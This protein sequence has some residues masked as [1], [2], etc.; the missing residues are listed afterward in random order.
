MKWTAEKDAEMRRLVTENPK[1][2]WV[3]I[4]ELMDA[5][6]DGCRK[7]GYKIGLY[8]DR[9]DCREKRLKRLEW[10]PEMDALLLS[11]VEQGASRRKTAAAIGCSRE[12]V[13]KRIQRIELGPPV[14]GGREPTE[15]E[16]AERAQKANV[17]FLNAIAEHHPERLAA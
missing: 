7:R 12:Q 16:W 3:V 17:R 11:M 6:A 4:A 13:D 15:A 9:A 10:T 2:S 14:Q 1:A 5:T 8:K